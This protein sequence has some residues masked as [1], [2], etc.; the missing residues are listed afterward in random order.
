MYSGGLSVKRLNTWAPPST[1]APYA[2]PGAT[3]VGTNGRGAVVWVPPGYRARQRGVPSQGMTALTPR[4]PKLMMDP[5]DRATW[6]R[7]Y[8]FS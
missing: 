6:Q 2:V 1:P 5:L 3:Q 7:P 8:R 4:P